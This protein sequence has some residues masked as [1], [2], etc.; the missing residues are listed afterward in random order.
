M[1]FSNLMAEA[2]T[3]WA[4]L[5]QKI[6]W[7]GGSDGWLVKLLGT[8]TQVMWVAMA[9]V[10]AAGAIYAIYMGI[11][12]ARAESAE[13]REENKKRLINI[14]VSIIAVVVL[15][16]VFN[17]FLPMIIGAVVGTPTSDGTGIEKDPAAGG[18]SVQTIVNTAKVLLH[19]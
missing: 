3:D 1:N 12:M 4:T 5:A 15:I 17:V 10:G 8:L 6:G 11:K 13:M 19:M 9:L 7:A 16:V 18:N 14:I 2:I